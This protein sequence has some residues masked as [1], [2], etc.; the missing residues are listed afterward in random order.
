MQ[1]SGHFSR[2]TR[3]SHQKVSILDLLKLRMMEVVVTTGV[4]IQAKLQ[5]NHHCQQTN[6]QL[7]YRPDTLPQLTV[8]QPTVSKHQREDQHHKLCFVM[9]LCSTINTNKIEI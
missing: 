7:F 2:Q 5:S 3:V 1:F 9:T 4:I 6:T 8:T